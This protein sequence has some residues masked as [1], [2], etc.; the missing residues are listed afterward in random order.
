MGSASRHRPKCNPILVHGTPVRNSRVG[1]AAKL[2]RRAGVWT[3]AWTEHEKGY[4][5]GDRDGVRPVVKSPHYEVCSRAQGQ[6]V[7]PSAI[8]QLV[9][10]PTRAGCVCHPYF[11]GDGQGC[12]LRHLNQHREHHETIARTKCGQV[13]GKRPRHCADPIVPRR[14]VRV[15]R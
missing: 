4:R 13:D 11:G 14:G 9:Y 6:Q 7:R 10:P 15:R 12:V 8:V 5:S 3:C 2:P 1:S